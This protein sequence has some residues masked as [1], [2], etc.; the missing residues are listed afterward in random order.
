ML[1]VLIVFKMHPAPWEVSSQ[2]CGRRLLIF[3][4]VGNR[5]R[6]MA[7]NGAVLLTSDG[8]VGLRKKV[9]PLYNHDAHRGTYVDDGPILDCMRDIVHASVVAGVKYSRTHHVIPSIDGGK[10]RKEKR[11]ARTPYQLQRANIAH[12]ECGVDPT[13]ETI[14]HDTNIYS[15]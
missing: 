7:S 3:L 1:H 12:C 13:R 11:R 6:W 15:S 4:C 8:E 10:G 5:W 2:R 9:P 14:I